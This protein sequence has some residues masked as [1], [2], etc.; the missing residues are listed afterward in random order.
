MPTDDQIQYILIGALA[1]AMLIT[2]IR[3]NMNRI[4]VTKLGRSFFSYISRNPRKPSTQANVN[5]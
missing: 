2:H 5:G 4:A 3:V 1:A